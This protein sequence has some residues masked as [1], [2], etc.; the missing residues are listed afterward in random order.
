MCYGYRWG[1]ELLWELQDKRKKGGGSK[2]KI[3]FL[4]GEKRGGKL[5]NFFRKGHV[6]FMIHRGTQVLESSFCRHRI[7]RY[8][9][10]N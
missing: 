8:F 5:I 1:K 7:D 6:V 9:G 10:G 3:P 2:E 4:T